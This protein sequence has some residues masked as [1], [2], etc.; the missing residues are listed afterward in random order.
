[1]LCASLQQQEGVATGELAGPPVSD[2][3]KARLMRLYA[4]SHQLDL[5]TCEAYGDSYADLPML[6]AVGRPHAVRPD[7]RL[8]AV[9]AQRSWPVMDW[10]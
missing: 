5:A 8:A 10:E 2:G 1:M 4:E 6:E 3:E 7:R 9:A